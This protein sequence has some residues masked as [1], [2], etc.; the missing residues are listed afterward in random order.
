MI[1]A[2]LAIMVAFCVRVC[3]ESIA[4]EIGASDVRSW[5][6]QE[7][8][9]AK[10][11]ITLGDVVFRY[12]LRLLPTLDDASL[13]SLRSRVEGRPDHPERQTLAR[14][15]DARDPEG[16]SVIELVYPEEGRFRLSSTRP[17]GGYTDI[18]R[19]REGIA[20]LLSAGVV[21][22]T[23]PRIEAQRFDYGSQ[24]LDAIRRLDDAIYGGLRPSEGA[25]VRIGEISY[26]PSI[27]RWL[28]EISFDDDTLLY[29]LRWDAELGRAF[30]ESW[31]APDDPSTPV[32]DESVTSTFEDWRFEPSLDRHVSRRVTLRFGAGYGDSMSILEIE[33][34]SSGDLNARLRVPE[35]GGD[36]VIRGT[37]SPAQFNDYR[38]GR[39]FEA[40]YDAEGGELERR[41]V[42][43]QGE[44]REARSSLRALGIGAAV[45]VGLALIAWRAAAGRRPVV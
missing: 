12:R 7:I 18:A 17:D 43:P 21:T 30:V 9:T 32:F 36:D 38:P 20:W 35:M 3:P 44:V 34:L 8:A 37:I 2:T 33:R 45:I 6:E 26:E 23:D 22:L 27:D 4:Q 31:S 42:T 16:G 40:R 24:E 10:A 19:S 1:R 29:R 13:E 14:E 5:I 15:E 25:A 39:L 11:E 41:L 28:A